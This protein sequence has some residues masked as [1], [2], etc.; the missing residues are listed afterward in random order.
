MQGFRGQ[1]LAD[2]EAAARTIAAVSRAAM[3][4]GAALQ[5]LEINPLLV[6]PRGQGAVALDALLIATAD[7]ASS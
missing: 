4:G 5:E 1:P 6:K 2:V 7:K 3:A